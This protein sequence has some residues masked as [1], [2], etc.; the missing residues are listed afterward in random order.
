MTQIP[1]KNNW[2]TDI[3][4]YWNGQGADLLAFTVMRDPDLRAAWDISD[5][6]YL[7]LKDCQ[8]NIGNARD[9]DSEYQKFME[10][11]QAMITPDDPFPLHADEETKNKWIEI[12]ERGTAWMTNYYSDGIRSILTPEQKQKIQEVH[13]ANMEDYPIV[14]P[15]I[16]EALD[17]TDAQKQQMEEIKK[18]LEPEFEK[19]LEE[20]VNDQL[21]LV[22]MMYD[23]FEKLGVKDSDGMTKE[24]S[25]VSKILAKS[26]EYKE[27][28]D[29][30]QSA[31]KQFATQ[32]K[33][34]MFTILTVEKVSSA[35]QGLRT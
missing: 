1:M 19:N 25:T 18:E 33:T 8:D 34:K 30:A 17:L 11:V 13:L 4:M 9:N 26:P 20:F 3:R 7:Q 14:S 28:L 6:Q 32:F 22:N 35:Q 2:K 5:E 24:E 21:L 15:Y 12:E 29:R 16:F 10:E 31:S 27:V 23:E